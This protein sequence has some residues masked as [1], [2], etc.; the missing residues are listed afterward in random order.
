MPMAVGSSAASAVQRHEPVSRRMVRHVVPQG[1]WSTH[2]TI[3]HTAV[4]AV[5]PWAASS[6]PRAAVP[7]VST[8]LP[9]CR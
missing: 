9:V 3:M 6:W 1:K 8:R 4:S 2:S 7:P 5:Q